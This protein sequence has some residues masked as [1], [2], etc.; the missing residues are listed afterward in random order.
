[1]DTVDRPQLS[2]FDWDSDGKLD[3][4]LGMGS[5]RLRFFKGVDPP[6]GQPTLEDEYPDLVLAHACQV[7]IFLGSADGSLHLAYS[8]YFDGGACSLVPT[9]WDWDSDGK[10]E[11]IVGDEQ[12]KLHLCKSMISRRPSRE[13]LQCSKEEFKIL[14]VGSDAS[15]AACD[16]DKDGVPDLMVYGRSELLVEPHWFRRNESGVALMNPAHPLDGFDLG[17]NAV[18]TLVDWDLDG[19]LDLI[20]GSDDGRVWYF[21]WHNGSFHSMNGWDG[22]FVQIDAKPACLKME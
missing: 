9:V 6:A 17:A 18:P 3:L 5:G 4:L 12:G 22:P 10:P 19:D 2:I 7:D 11:L 14:G 21:P 1:M 16:W 20:V 8:H 15:P 13:R